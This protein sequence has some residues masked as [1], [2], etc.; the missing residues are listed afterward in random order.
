M[1]RR[2][3]RTW[4]RLAWGATAGLSRWLE[5]NETVAAGVC[6]QQFCSL[7]RGKRAGPD[8]YATSARVF[9]G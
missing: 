4:H 1:D 8:I 3:E 5:V 2:L 6:C 9:G 7:G